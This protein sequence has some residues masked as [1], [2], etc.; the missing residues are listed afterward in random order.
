MWLCRTGKKYEYYTAIAEHSELFLP[1]EG[2]NVDFSSL[3]GRSAFRELVQSEM[4]SDNQTSISNWSGQLYAFCNEIEVEDL[5]L[6]PER[7][8]FYSLAQITGEY[9]Y[10]ENSIY[11]L[12]HCRN[13]VLLKRGIP[14][15]IF[16]QHIKYSLQAYRTLFQVKNEDE[17]KETILKWK[18][19]R[20]LNG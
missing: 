5:I 3:D 1:W 2:F 19:E 4:H 7:V 6:L 9:R 14:R 13:V 10:C 11:G 20:C 16:P 8:G 17:V 18:K 12:H 15:D